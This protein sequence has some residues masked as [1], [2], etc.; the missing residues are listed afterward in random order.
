MIAWILIILLGLIAGLMV[1]A[2]NHRG[3]AKR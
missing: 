3:G 1:A 2:A